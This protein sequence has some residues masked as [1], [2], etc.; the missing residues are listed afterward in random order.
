MV[1]KTF[2]GL[3]TDSSPGNQDRIRLQTIKGKVGYRITKFQIMS[4][5]PYDANAAEHI[6]KIYKSEQTTIDAVVNF[7]DSDLL[8]VAIINNNTSGYNYPSV[9]TIIFDTE[10]FNQDIYITHKE[11][12]NAVNCNYYMELELIPLASDEAAITTV[13]A[14]RGTAVD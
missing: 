4:D 12:L 2:R 14:M 10:V 13:K 9:P 5:T 11:V 6:V 8:G 3:L 7:T 1:V